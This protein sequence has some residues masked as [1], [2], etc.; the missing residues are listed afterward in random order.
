MAG[1]LVLITGA[2]GHIGFRTLVKLLE[3]GFRAR[4]S[5][6]KL[7]SAQKLKDLPSIKPYTESVEF[8]EV[9]DFLAE[10]AFDEAVQ[11]ADYVLHLASPIPDDSHIGGQFDIYE[12]YINPAI[13]GTIGMLK[14]ASKSTSIKR[15]IITASVANLELK[16]GKSSIG[17]DDLKPAPSREDMQKSP[18]IAYSGA[19]ILAHEATLKYVEDNK[20]PFDVLYILPGY[21]QGRNEPVTASKQLHDGPSSNETMVQY[22]M[23]GKSQVPMPTNFVHVDDVAVAHVAALTSLEAKNGERFVVC[24]APFKSYSEIEVLVKKLFPEEV[25]SGLLPLGGE[26]AC[27]GGPFDSSNTQEKLGVKY[28]DLES[29]VESLIGQYVE[30]LKKEKSAA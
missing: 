20:L 3:A 10:G 23:G 19:K 9:P 14:S 22:V 24:P 16:E 29:M 4:I 21:V 17:P 2:T 26:Q 30:L 8:V 27:R 11:G 7:S 6:R 15:V 13:Q 5:S 12:L 28:H 1:P 25:K 18:W